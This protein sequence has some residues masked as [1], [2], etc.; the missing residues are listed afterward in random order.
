M[1]AL[2]VDDE[3]HMKQ[4]IEM[5]LEGE[6]TGIEKILYAANGAEALE[7][8]EQ[9]RPDIIFC[10]ME[11]PVMGGKKLLE[12][13]VK[14]KIRIQVIAISGYND[15]QYV[16]ATLVANGVDYI[17][18]PFGRETLMNAVNKAIIRING[19]REDAIKIRQ[20]E[21][22]GM[23]MANSVLQDFCREEEG[24]RERIREAFLKLGAKDR[25]F[26]VISVLNRNLSQVI[27]KKYEG[28]RDLCFF[29]VGNIL[30]DVFRMYDFR[31]EVF[32]D[33]FKCQFFVQGESEGTFHITDKMKIY[34]KKLA[35]TL[36]VCI[37]WVVSKEPVMWEEL[38]SSIAGQNKLLS[39]R[40][41]CGN[42]KSENG[43]EPESALGLELRLMNVMEKKNQL[44]VR[45]IV[46]DYCQQIRK[47]PIRLYQL[48][49][50]TADI[51]LLMQRFLLH[52]E[53]QLRME[54]LSVWINDIDIW[55]EEVTLRLEKITEN[56]AEG[57][58]PAGK[59]YSY[60]KEHYREDITLSTIAGDF[61]QTPQY[62]ARIFKSRYDMTVVTA[63]MQI[64]LQKACELLE[65]GVRSVAQIAEMVGYED[66]NYFSRVFKKHIGMTPVQYRRRQENKSK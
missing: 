6:D 64:R 63:I 58:D 13:I 55:E 35:D 42:D 30:R 65:E 34:E 16:H 2:I 7:M 28:D 59:I 23:A 46:H 5:M 29:T 38:G 44:R 37:T 61:Y 8:I 47:K 9:E 32:V 10:D 33:E 4:A 11:M 48:Q 40:F 24:N 31:Q 36:G 57:E 41:V 19:E 18:K 22:M 39:Q 3:I 66:E 60:I 25:G 62:V 12:E 43:R 49:S 51:N 45:E 21:Q 14:R 27:R 20:H 17:L 1:K 50:C 15:F 54:P 56:F 53:L 52:Q 26:W